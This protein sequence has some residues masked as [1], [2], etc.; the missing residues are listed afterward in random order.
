VA[1]RGTIAWYRGKIATFRGKVATFR[2]K[3]ATF[4]GKVAGGIRTPVA[5]LA[6]LPRYTTPET[7]LESV[8]QVSDLCCLHESETCATSE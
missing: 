7:T 8:A 3:V 6:T 4:R 5:T 1:W 2:G